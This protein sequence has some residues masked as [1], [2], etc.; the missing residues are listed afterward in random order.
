MIRSAFVV[1]FCL[2]NLSAMAG[3]FNV[4]NRAAE[5]EPLLG[6]QLSLNMDD[7]GPLGLGEQ[8]KEQFVNRSVRKRSKRSVAFAATKTTVSTA[9]SKYI[10]GNKAVLS[11]RFQ[12]DALFIYLRNLRI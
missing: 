8:S 6:Q 9:I 7:R 12:S 11:L 5:N 2:L 10:S 1:L 3:Q 4:P